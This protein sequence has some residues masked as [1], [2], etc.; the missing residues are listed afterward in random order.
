[1]KAKSRVL[2]IDDA[3]MMHSIVTARLAD[4]CVS[5]HS[6]FNGEEGLALAKEIQPDLILLDVEM[7]SPN[8][9]E[10]CR[11]LKDDPGLSSI[12]I[13]FL[14]SANSTEEKI[15]GLNL[16]AIDF[17]TKPFDAGELQARVRAGL[18][19]KELLD[20]LSR[21]AMIDGLTGLWNRGYLDQRLSEELASARRYNRKFSCIMVDA[22]HFKAVNDVHGHGF[23]DVVLQ[24]IANLIQE[25]SRAEDVACRYGG[26]EFAI[27]TR[28]TSGLAAIHLAERIRISVAG[29][30]FTRGSISISATCSIGLAEWS[31]EAPNLLDRADQAL[32]ASKQ[33]GR[34][35]VTLAPL[36]MKAA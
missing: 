8:G 10:V 26:E 13:I 19:N 5:L 2:M 35:R 22:D 3:K 7:P 4:D 1:M 36:T 34:N 14:T 9:F 6:A 24:G 32:Y 12:P 28:E 30:K 29:M 11:R 15:R 16:G 20:L 21:K 27:L 25:A 18:R 23:G 17:V 31:P 33:G